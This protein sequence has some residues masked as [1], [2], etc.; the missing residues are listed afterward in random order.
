MTDVIKPFKILETRQESGG[1]TGV[2]YQS[3]ITEIV[4]GKR[5]TR[6]VR[7]YISVPS[8]ED[9]DQYLFNFLQESGWL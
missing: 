6:G 5:R 3:E 2:F 8:G 4:D 7:A 1:S 9:I